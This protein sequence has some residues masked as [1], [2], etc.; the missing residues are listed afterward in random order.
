MAKTKNRSLWIDGCKYLWNRKHVH[1]NEYVRSPCSEILTV[2]L[3]DQKTGPLRIAFDQDEA[4]T[5]WVIGYP[6]QGVI[7]NQTHSFNLNEPG[8]VTALI[9]KA[10]TLGWVPTQ[11]KLPYDL[12]GIQLLNDGS[13]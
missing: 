9:R 2:Y 5:H 13:I 12:N 6:N 8:V 11:S 10:I 7:W 4:D 3:A 1:K